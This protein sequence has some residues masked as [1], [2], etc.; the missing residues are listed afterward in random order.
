MGRDWVGNFEYDVNHTPCGEVMRERKTCYYPN[1]VQELFPQDGFLAD[2][3]ATSYMATPLLNSS[4]QPIGHLCVIDTKPLTGEQRARSILEIFAGRAAAEL[5]RKQAE[6]AL[7]ESQRRYALASAA[8][9]VG[10][11]DWNLEHE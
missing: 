5:Q 1:H 8:G 10:V 4:G 6:E 3:G 11:W 9:R 2:L 7:R